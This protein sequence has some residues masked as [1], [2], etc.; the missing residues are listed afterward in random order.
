M[1]YN[2]DI[3][4]AE[5]KTLRLENHVHLIKVGQV[6]KSSEADFNFV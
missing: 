3:F 6:R 2:I 4:N 1:S 5:T